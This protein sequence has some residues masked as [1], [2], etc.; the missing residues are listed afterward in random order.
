M[1][2]HFSDETIVLINNIWCQSLE[3]CFLL[4][5]LFFFTVKTYTKSETGE[6]DALVLLF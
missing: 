2:D 4:Y 3:K 1:L 6:A 5:C